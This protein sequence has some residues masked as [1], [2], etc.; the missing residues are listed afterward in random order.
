[1]YVRMLVVTVLGVL[2]ALTP[3]S[4]YAQ[5]A[6]LVVAADERIA[7]DLAT[8][9]RSIV[10]AGVVE[11]DV[12]SWSGAIEI[13]GSV[14]GDVVSYAGP[15]TL[16]PGAEVRGSVLALGGMLVRADAALVTGQVLGG[17]PVAG[18]QVV[19]SV[20]AIFQPDHTEGDVPRP[21]VSGTLAFTALLLV[22]ACAAVWPRRTAGLSRALRQAPRAS[23][24]L[25]V[26]SA[27]LIGAITLFGTALLALSLVGL[28]LILPLL[29]LV[30]AP[31]LVGLTG[32]AR[33]VGE[34][35][36]RPGWSPVAIVV[37]GALV[38][39]IPLGLLGIN[40]PI[41]S[42]ALF[43]LIAGVGLGAAILSRGGAMNVVATTRRP[44]EL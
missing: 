10:V 41:W 21:L 33:L 19:S 2:L 30:Q 15:V 37:V 28:P 44:E 14:H 32:M 16:G 3:R 20:F 29:L 35:V 27:L 18:G 13:T 40:A 42:A 26:L 11:G 1:M 39:L 22:A 8:I 17:E 7:G 12:T 6:A 38:L 4:A 36:G 25:G 31:F 9:G 5:S 24:G 34:E 43:Y 23:A